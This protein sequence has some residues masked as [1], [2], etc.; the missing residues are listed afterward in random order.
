MLKISKYTDI[1]P[2]LEE[3]K[4]ISGLISSKGWAESNAGNFSVNITDLCKKIKF[5]VS[6]S[7]S[8]KSDKAYKHLRNLY[9]LI[10]CSGSRMR[11]IAI[12]PVQGL[13]L[14][15]FNNSGNAYTIIPL[16]NNKSKTPTSELLTHLEVQNLLAGK[17]TDEK[18]VLHTHPAEAVAVTHLKNFSS[19]KSINKLISAIQPEVPVLF[20]EGIGYL[21]YYLTGSKKLALKT[22][23]KI[24]RHKIVIWEKH[25]CVSTGKDLNEAFD[26]TDVL[27]KSIKIFFMCLYS[28]NKYEGL[29]VYQVK[30]L[31]K[32]NKK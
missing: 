28:G 18:V 10:T 11:D 21:P 22:K 31:K 27:I 5:Q 32:P 26:N 23:K 12:N 20:P 2:V 8:V 14:L 29:N 19:E 1:I 7:G 9:I 15:Y 13:C 24:N 17:K 16:D 25:G 6:E 4:Q 30:E 3:I